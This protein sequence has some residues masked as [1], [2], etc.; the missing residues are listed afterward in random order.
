MGING[1]SKF[2]IREVCLK[3]FAR[4]NLG[5]FTE[6]YRGDNPVLLLYE[7]SCL[8]W[9]GIVRCAPANKALCAMADDYPALANSIYWWTAEQVGSRRVYDSFVREIEEAGTSLDE[10]ATEI[11]GDYVN[12]G[13]YGGEKKN[14][15][16]FGENQP[17]LG[18]HRISSHLV[19]IEALER[20]IQYYQRQL[21]QFGEHALIEAVEEAEYFNKLYPYNSYEAQM[22]DHEFMKIFIGMPRARCWDDDAYQKELAKIKEQLL[23]ALNTI[24]RF[25]KFDLKVH[26]KYVVRPGAN[27]RVGEINWNTVFVGA[28]KEIFLLRARLVRKLAWPQLYHDVKSA[29]DDI[30]A[31]IDAAKSAPAGLL[32][33]EFLQNLLHELA[34][35]REAIEYAYPV[36]LEDPLL[37]N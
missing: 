9:T 18:M 31:K 25:G 27:F 3:D 26:Y 19:P 10:A 4:I 29:C 11:F 36:I 16:G 21:T 13:G 28:E 22:H 6:R 7:M 17:L 1:K 20:F 23:D 34:L 35:C 2:S 8:P 12:W 15:P 30:E 5:V 37:G 32:D 33:L 24:A 14:L